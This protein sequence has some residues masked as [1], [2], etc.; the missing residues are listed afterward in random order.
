MIDQAP[1][2]L[3]S[4]WNRHIL[5]A[6]LIITLL[7]YWPG[8][9]GPFLFDDGANL[10]QIERWLAGRA[11]WYEAIFGTGSGLLLRPVSMATFALNAS[12][13]GM[14]PVL[15]KLT[16]LVLHLGCGLLVWRLVLKLATR[17]PRLAANAAV[18]SSVVAALWLLH[19]LNASTVLYVVQRMA[20]L[21]TLFVL[22]ALCVYVAGREALDANRSKQAHRY[23]FL[24]FPCLLLAGM[25]SKENAAIAPLLCVV[26]ELGYFARS[27]AR[28]SVRM[29][30]LVFL[31]LPAL[32][33]LVLGLINPHRL[34][35]AYDERSFTL[36]ERLLTQGRVLID[37]V[38]QLVAPNASR[39]G[40]YFDDFPVST[41]LVTPATTLLSW[42]CLLLISAV[43]LLARRRNASFFAGWLF[44]L[45]AHAI[46]ST[47]LPLEIYFEHRNYL[48]SVG[49]LLALVAGFA[50]LWGSARTTPRIRHAVGTAACVAFAVFLAYSTL[51]RALVWR[52]MESIATEGVKHHPHSLRANLD[53]ATVMLQSN[54]LEQSITA[55]QR[56]TTSAVPGNRMIGHLGM[57]TT[58]CLA[59]GNPDQRDLDS[60]IANADT[61]LRLEDYQA[62]GLLARVSDDRGC[63][64]ITPGAIA[65]A[66]VEV[67]HAARSQPDVRQPKWRLRMLA[68]QQLA[69]AN[70]LPE[71]LEQAKLAWQPTADVGVGSVLVQIYALMGMPEDAERTL[72]EMEN[73]LGSFE[74]MG[75][76]EIQRLRESVIPNLSPAATH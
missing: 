62:F 19:P 61:V 34:I 30:F 13:G 58:D 14:S 18:V 9:A 10:A 47:V 56:L 42:T 5:L 43:A 27:S 50:G 65:D 31:L 33:G 40:L 71:A 46:E 20:Q 29:F 76:A 54:R 70:R 15:F 67:L 68:A 44:F 24:V 60:A 38:V 6:V 53:Y 3:R 36:I 66:M 74:S 51:E 73:R 12:L 52:S 35:G 45:A 75:F 41:S 37:Y 16:N 59:T 7:I 64:E 11:T 26:I 72:Q 1:A 57:A 32:A 49:L 69:R 2:G 8:L 21:S 22:A 55:M 63:G 4:G 39:M 17:D 48:P 23:L 28:W 25:L